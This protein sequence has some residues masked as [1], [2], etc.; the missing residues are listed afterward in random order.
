[1]RYEHTAQ[2]VVAVL[3]SIGT[4]RQVPFAVPFWMPLFG[5][6]D[7]GLSDF[8]QSC[9]ARAVCI[10]TCD[11]PRTVAVWHVHAFPCMFMQAYDGAVAAREALHLFGLLLWVQLV[12]LSTCLPDCFAFCAESP[13]KGRS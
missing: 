8:Q 4:V 7:E 13:K 11:T 10:A 1:M 5:Q 12:T 9:T 6:G 2:H 3:G